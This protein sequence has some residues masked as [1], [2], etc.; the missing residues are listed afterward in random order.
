MDI[1]NIH[2]VR[3]GHKKLMG[4]CNSHEV[5]N[6]KWYSQLHD[7]NWLAFMSYIIGASCKVAK[8]LKEKKNVLVHCSDGWDRTSQILSLAQM[9][10]DPYFR[11][12]EGFE[13][14]VMKDWV[15]FGHQFN[16]RTGHGNKNDKDEQ[17]SP[18]FLQFLDC[19]HQLIH[20][21]PFA[22]EFNDKFLFDIAHHIYSCQ[23][24]TF[25]CNSY[26]EMKQY[27]MEEKTINIWSLLNSQKER[28]LNTYYKPVD[29]ENPIILNPSYHMKQLRL[30]EEFFLYFSWLSKPNYHHLSDNV[31]F[32]KDFYE[33]M[34]LKEKKKTKD[35]KQEIEELKAKLQKY[36]AI[37]E[38]PA[39]DSQE[40]KEDI[41][42]EEPVFDFID[43]EEN[44]QQ[45]NESPAVIVCGDNKDEEE[46][47]L[48]TTEDG[49]KAAEDVDGGKAAVVE[50]EEISPE[51][52]AERDLE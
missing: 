21:Y 39:N 7:S 18:V 51:A 16:L 42:E 11:T 32:H 30:W 25:L 45:L 38:K 10:L 2:H 1:D 44:Q 50:E 46:S 37:E 19:I 43:Q 15:Y 14:L 48:K 26:Q 20:Q 52:K 29:P 6:N 40:D 23:F 5:A 33:V 9:M 41:K 13:V 27:K 35:M 34:Y 47:P 17:R 12:I 4:M 28:Y 36:E 31:V 24:G 8:S 49:E 3:D 22:F